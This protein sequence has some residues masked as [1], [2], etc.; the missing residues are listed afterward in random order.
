MKPIQEIVTQLAETKGRPPSRL[1]GINAFDRLFHQYI[2]GQTGTGKSTLLLQMMQQDL[3]KGQGF[4]LV[5]EV[6]VRF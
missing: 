5:D 2:I 6:N 4:C 1:F 3:A